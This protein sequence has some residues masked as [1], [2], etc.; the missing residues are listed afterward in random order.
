MQYVNRSHLSRRRRLRLMTGPV[1]GLAAAAAEGS[2]EDSCSGTSEPE[3]ATPWDRDVDQVDV[4]WY[5][6][7]RTPD[8]GRVV[9]FHDDRTEQERQAYFPGMQQVRHLYEVTPV[10]VAGVPEQHWE[11]M[12][13]LRCQG[14]QL[15]E[16]C[17]IHIAAGS[18]ALAEYAERIGVEQ[19]RLAPR[20][21]VVY[22]MAMVARMDLTVLLQNSRLPTPHFLLRQQAYG[23]VTLL[24]PADAITR[25]DSQLTFSAVGQVL[26]YLQRLRELA[27]RS[28]SWM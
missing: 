27:L 24:C 15:P 9:W 25:R 8:L 12:C 11:P 4:L 2:E 22:W 5:A 6:R 20:E 23:A 13:V 3:L 14:E 19:W 7:A 21:S 18:G 26:P 1:V 28:G 17:P 16:V 10:E